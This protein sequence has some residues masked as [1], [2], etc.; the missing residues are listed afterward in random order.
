MRLV[1]KETMRTSNKPLFK[2]YEVIAIV[3]FALAALAIGGLNL[4]Y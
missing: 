4:I 2:I 1:G 3:A